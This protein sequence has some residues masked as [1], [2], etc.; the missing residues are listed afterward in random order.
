VFVRF[1]WDDAKA[2][3]NLKKHG[4]NFLAA[5]RV[6]EDPYFIMEQDREVDDE[7]RWK[8]V[9]KAGDVTLLVVAHTVADEEEDLVYRIISVRTANVHERRIYEANT[10]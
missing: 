7:E 5:T 6:F 4:V 10:H 2:E 8:T 9:G 3:S 1:E